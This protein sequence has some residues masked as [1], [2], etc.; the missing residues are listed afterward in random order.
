MS[1]LLWCDVVASWLIDL[2][3]ERFDIFMLSNET[4][5]NPIV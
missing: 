2:N 5:W 1:P 3:L 4:F